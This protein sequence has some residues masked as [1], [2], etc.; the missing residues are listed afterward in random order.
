MYLHTRTT[1]QERPEERLAQKC[2]AEQVTRLVHGGVYL[3]AA[4]HCPL[5]ACVC[6][7]VCVQRMDL[8]MQ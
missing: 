3:F 8:D 4:L 1:L 2:L 7:C 5:H 6:V